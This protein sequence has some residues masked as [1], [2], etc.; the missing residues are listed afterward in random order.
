MNQI[1]LLKKIWKMGLALMCAGFLA[2]GGLFVA[3]SNSQAVI[4]GGGQPNLTVRT[5]VSEIEDP[6]QGWTSNLNTQAGRTVVFYVEIHNT[7]VQTLA[8]NV[9]VKAALPSGVSTS[10]TIPV[11][12]W[13]DNAGSV[14][15]AV[16]VNVLNPA[17]G[18]SLQYLPG[19]SRLT[20][21]FNGDGIREYDMSP[22]PDGV[23]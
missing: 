5:L 2:F 21:D 14:S 12:V 7:Q 1:E 11:T 4:I 20:W 13:A 8:E 6:S 9:K 15:S 19:S 22:I 16:T 3:I 17:S 18:G 23:T 10:H